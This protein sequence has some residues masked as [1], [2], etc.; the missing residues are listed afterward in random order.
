MTTI[1]IVVV[2]LMFQSRI[3]AAADALGFD[4]R[5]ADTAD[6]AASAIDARPDLVVIDLHAAGIDAAGTI[7]TAKGA[8]A[9]VLAF[10]RHTE[11]QILR[12][13]REAGADAGVARSQLVDEL[14]Q[15]LQALLL[16]AATPDPA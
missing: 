7:R 15:L 11:P 13:A 14:P 10:G 12:A 9:R 6:A 3:R 4:A 8:G 2:D 1:A 16:P 5:I